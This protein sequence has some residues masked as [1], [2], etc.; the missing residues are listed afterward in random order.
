MTTLQPILTADG[1]RAADRAAMNDW[2][3]PGRLL[4]ETAGRATA[5]AIAARYPVDGAHV[6]VLVGAG[7]NGGDGLVI[8]RVLAARGARVRCLTLATESDASDDTAANLHLLR[9]LA[10]EDGRLEV[11]DFED[12][13]QAAN[14]PADL[15]VDASRDACGRF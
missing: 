1:M 4:M 14:A 6:T 9:Q 7:N 11:V 5:D 2:G 8:A 10:A 13:R 15:V 3:V 12:V